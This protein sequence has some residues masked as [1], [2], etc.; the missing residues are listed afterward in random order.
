MKFAL[1]Q[2]ILT[3]SSYFFVIATG[4]SACFGPAL[5]V[6]NKKSLG[7]S[8]REAKKANVIAKASTLQAYAYPAVFPGK[9]SSNRSLFGITSLQLSGCQ[10][11]FLNV[12]YIL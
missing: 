10:I 7:L 6:S 8:S 11:K 1:K 3:S 9:R 12:L 4:Q 5:C 2:I